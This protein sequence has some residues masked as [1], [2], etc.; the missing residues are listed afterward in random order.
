VRLPSVPRV[1]KSDPALMISFLTKLSGR[2]LLLVLLVLL[3]PIII[4]LCLSIGGL[5]LALSATVVLA[6][7]IIIAKPVWLPPGY[8]NTGVRLTSLTLGFALASPTIWGAVIDW[9]CHQLSFFELMT[10]YPSLCERPIFALQPTEALLFFGIV[11]AVNFC[12]RDPTV[13]G[14]H[15]RPPADGFPDNQFLDWLPEFCNDLRERLKAIDRETNWRPVWY[16]PLEA[17][18]EVRS[19]R[20]TRRHINNLQDAIR[21]EKKSR[22]FL[23]LGAP[24]SGKS[25]ALRKLC[26]DMLG[27]VG[28]TRRVPIYV[29][30]REWTTANAWS[31]ENPPRIQDFYAFVVQRLKAGSDMFVE[32]FVDKYFAQMLRDGWLFLVLDSFDEIPSLLDEKEGSWLVRQLSEV[33]YRFI[34]G[35]HQSRGLLASRPFHSPSQEFESPHIL[36]ILPLSDHRIAT[37][38]KRFPVFRNKRLLDSLFRERN[39]LV[40]VARNPFYATLIGD[41]VERHSVL[42]AHQAAMFAD[43]VSAR[44]SVCAEQARRLGLTTDDV[45]SGAVEIAWLMLNVNQSGLEASTK[46]LSGL[47]PHI[48]IDPLINVLCYAR[49]GRKGA[50]E[51]PVFMF[52]HRRFAEYFAVL[53]LLENP[54]TVPIDAIPTDSGWRDALVLYTNLVDEHKAGEIAAFCWG[55]VQ[56]ISNGHGETLRGI[57]CLRFLHEAFSPRKGCIASFQEEFASLI[58]QRLDHNQ[59]LLFAKFAVEAA[60]LLDEQQLDRVVRRAIDVGNDWLTETTIKSCR[61]MATPSK[62]LE[63]KIKR[64]LTSL[65]VVSW[66]R[67]Q[68]E[69]LFSF[70]LSDA[71]RYVH[72]YC[73][74]RTLDVYLLVFGLG[75]LLLVFPL[76]LLASAVYAL[77]TYPILHFLSKAHEIDGQGRIPVLD[78]RDKAI[79]YLRVLVPLLTWILA[80]PVPK[81]GASLAGIWYEGW[82]IGQNSPF[83]FWIMAT[84]VVLMTPW[85][86][87]WDWVD[88]CRYRIASFHAM[89]WKRVIA[90]GVTHIGKALGEFVFWVALCGIVMGALVGFIYI[91]ETYLKEWKRVLFVV[92]LCV[93]SIWAYR[94]LSHWASDWRTYRKM[95]TKGFA[96]GEGVNKL[97]GELKTQWFQAKLVQRLERAGLLRRGEWPEDWRIPLK[98]VIWRLY[99]DRREYQGISGDGV[100][101]REQ[102][103]EIIN[104]LR[105]DYYRMKFVKSLEMQSITPKGDWP[106]GDIFNT[107]SDPAITTLARLE[108]RW[109]GLDR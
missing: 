5:T 41:Y 101:S 11:A 21:K 9:V 27:E 59:N 16:A 81:T 30:L 35:A 65:H 8:G 46:Q 3:T 86:K 43:Y 91:T 103:A 20:G 37:V 84:L 57:H 36:E 38:L 49:I 72:Y 25:V 29:N 74:A 17:Q 78:F 23:L 64:Y 7:L 96:S 107:A 89:G 85:Y 14:T 60:G 12:M 68:R 97:R 90:N 66:M 51:D 109:L 54:D 31:Q 40:P 39:D 10:R 2:E 45:L 75:G 87:G 63:L 104:R 62:E 70:S 24:G 102:I 95:L 108:E 4:F 99:S 47:L 79:T 1:E 18:V 52:V 61:H 88:E 44:L 69:L 105:T 58:L 55:H 28:L 67:H 71:F 80:A 22:T 32:E 77:L 26:I 6:T 82:L 48:R 106:A 19:E 98:I 83:F 53:K 50:G 100:I 94:G 13:L 93:L 15:P 33:I 34:T 73:R 76:Q 56:T 92:L 42:P